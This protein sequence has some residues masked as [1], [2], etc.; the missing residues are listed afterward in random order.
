[1]SLRLWWRVH[2]DPD[3]GDRGCLPDCAPSGQGG[4][5]VGVGRRVVIAVGCVVLLAGCG[6]SSSPEAGSV[7]ATTSVGSVPAGLRD[8]SRAGLEAAART[9]AYGYL[10]AS[11][12]TLLVVLDPDPDPACADDPKPPADAMLAAGRAHLREFQEMVEARVGVPATSVVVKSV[13]VRNFTA[14]R[15]E[16]AA[17]FGYPESVQGN[18]NWNSYVYS[19]G[20]WHL[21]GCE[22]FAPFGGHESGLMSETTDA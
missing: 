20:Y 3:L 18:A 14:T 19:H 7:G 4:R 13:K 16:A 8:A 15:G 9:W 10:R 17:D 2:G 5:V 6:S 22:T 12:P 1:M 21:A 11:V